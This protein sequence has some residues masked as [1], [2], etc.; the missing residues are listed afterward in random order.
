MKSFSLGITDVLALCHLL[1][2]QKK[3]TLVIYV[4]TLSW[5]HVRFEVLSFL[6]HRPPPVV[7]YHAEFLLGNERWLQPSAAS[8]SPLCVF[9][10]VADFVWEKPCGDICTGPQAS[11]PSHVHTP[12]ALTRGVN[13]LL[14]YINMHMHAHPHTLVHRPAF[15]W[16]YTHMADLRIEWSYL[17]CIKL[18]NTAVDASFKVIIVIIYISNTS[19]ENKS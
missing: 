15:I 12:A 11:A 6:K 2:C 19:S 17:I 1:H 10:W 16:E 9:S 13:R 5:A 4:Q 14:V 18:L 3:L 7:Q 8:L